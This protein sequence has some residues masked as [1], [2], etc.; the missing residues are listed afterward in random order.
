MKSLAVIWT[1]IDGI[2]TGYHRDKY[3]MTMTSII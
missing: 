3:F 1:L 2:I